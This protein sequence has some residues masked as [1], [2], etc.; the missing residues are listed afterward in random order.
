LI[1]WSL[2]VA[3]ALVRTAQEAVAQAVFA[4]QLLQLAVEAH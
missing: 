2:P 3:V 4:A 1:T